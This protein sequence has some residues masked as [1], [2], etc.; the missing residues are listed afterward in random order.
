MAAKPSPA[1]S[2]KSGGGDDGQ[3]RPPPIRFPE[4]NGEATFW[5]VYITN[6]NSR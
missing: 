2:G 4:G 6:V 3:K 5:D 1:S